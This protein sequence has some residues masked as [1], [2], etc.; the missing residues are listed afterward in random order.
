[1]KKPL[2]LAAIG[3]LLL[4][5][6]AARPSAQAPSLKHFKN[7]F[8]TGDYVVSG[9]SL[10]RKGVGGRASET[11]EVKGVPDNVDIVAAYLYL[12]T[13]EV[14]QW[15]GID[16]AR[17]NGIDLGAGKASVAKALNWDAATPPCWSVAWGGSRRLVTY[18]A[19][20]LR[21]LPI[22]SNGKTRVN[23]THAIEVPDFGI[24]FPDTDE[25]VAESGSERGPRAIGAS[26]VVVYRDST[27]SFRGI[28]I[29]DGG[30]TKP[31]FSTMN[32]SIQGFYQASTSPAA[33]MTALVGD[34]RPYL[35]ERLKF[36]GQLIATGPFASTAGPKWDNPPFPNLPLPPGASTAVV[37]VSPDGLLSDCLSF[38]AVVFSTEVQDSDGD[39]LIDVWESSTTTIFDPMRQPLPN[40]RAMGADPG[41]KDLF[42]EI[43]YMFTEDDPLP[44]IGAPTYGG[45][46]K[47]SHSHLPT[48]AALKLVGDAFA[49]AP[50]GRINVHFDVG[51]P[52]PAGEADPYII[53]GPGLARGGE[54]IN[55][56]ATVCTRS[57]GDPPDVCQFWAY[58]GTVG[59]KTGFQ[60]IRD[61]VLSEPA[62]ASAGTEDDDPCDVPG[63]CVRRFDRNRKDTFRYA[64]F[65]HA[66]GIPKSEDPGNPDFQVPRTNTGV[67]D[68][69][70][71]DFIVSLGAFDDANGL[72]VGTPF[73]QASTMLHEM[74][75]GFERRHGGEALEPNCKP[76]YFS[77]MNY[78]YQLRGL[79]DDAGVPH[80]NL[81]GEAFAGR[82]ID[83]TSLVDGS[84]SFL[85]YRLGWY[86]P[87]STSYLGSL[88]TPVSKHCDGSPLLPTDPAMV[89]IDARLAAAAVDWNAD[90]TAD[91]SAFP[92]DVNFNGRTSRPDLSPELL[93]GSNDWASIVLNQVGARRSAGGLFFD[94]L[95][96]P[97]VGPLSLDAGRGD[98][99][100]GDLGRGD[101]G[102]GDLGRGDL[103]RG[104]LGRGDLGRGDLGTILGR[105]DLG[106]GD[107][108]G[109]D[110]FVGDPGSPFGELDFDTAVDLGK[111]PPN[112]FRACVLGE[113][114]PTG[115][116]PLH[117]I[118]L[119]WTSPTVG[120]VAQY[121]ALRVLGPALTPEAVASAVVVGR[122]N[123]ILGQIDYSL[124]D[125]TSLINGQS[126]TFFARAVY[127]DGTVSDPSNI[128]TV[129]AVNDAPTIS[130][131]V[132]TTINENGT[133]G[134]LAFAIS[135]DDLSS[136]AITGTSSNT[137]LVPN[138]NIVFGGGGAN[139]T[140]TVTP[141]PNRSGSATITVRVTDASGVPATASFVL[142]VK[143][144]V[145]FKFK[146][147]QNAPPPSGATFNAGSVIP[148]KWTYLSGSTPVASA[149]VG[150]TVTVVGPLPGGVI[151]TF[152]NTDPGDSG[153]RYSASTKTWTF[154]LQTKDAGGKPYPVGTY[155]A[156]IS[157][158]TPGY[159]SSPTF[160]IRLK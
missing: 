36:N 57:A 112:E 59:W 31:A 39:G 2:L 132:D 56:L 55:E 139:R 37:Q 20:V 155:E 40:L 48:H 45:V 46:P 135:D 123:A 72:P 110:L 54:A 99:G 74:G 69:P 34:G 136:V 38:S 122:L 28:V 52:Y 144:A 23:G 151:R 128:V 21:F 149:D 107:L 127:L 3:A 131:L 53:R 92:Q 8:L 62:S 91:T 51:E 87:L 63:A 96:R 150:H 130:G 86:A 108:G 120:A 19:D 43:G 133:T 154:N 77:A 83:E 50:T 42:V 160:Q 118:R 82:T 22:G 13:A 41:Q 157:P 106:R 70:G 111:T 76:L 68:F 75:H 137:T 16:H 116:T 143:A 158:T 101:L 6:G 84:L 10:W 24:S 47:P 32:L 18:R 26:L 78:L 124:I 114:C 58:P 88:G 25:A 7:F 90:G 95:G 4:Q 44:D 49:N 129:V 153:F 142:T 89:R 29:Q 94:S 30:V 65:A 138:A 73:M 146:N 147:V 126:Y 141:A 85:P 67:G 1:M 121:E 134:P 66:V 14:G 140:V 11:I 17:F 100:R 60:F 5:P 64:L 156:T 93:A 119:D 81:S 102:R 117:R 61:A 104:D 15:S 27:H 152:T 159:A 12:Q 79:L 125:L 97:S 113:N 145:T 105:G 148:M 33:R 71:G 103:G 35:S 115:A 9:T 109:G 98:L 80:L